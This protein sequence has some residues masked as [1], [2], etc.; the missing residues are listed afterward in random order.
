MVV[1]NLRFGLLGST[2]KSEF[3]I[4]I[5][6]IL[7]NQAGFFHAIGCKNNSRNIYN[8]LNGNHIVSSRS[9]QRY[10]K[11]QTKA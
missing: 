4:K 9:I 7:R 8:T 10:F 1:W 5:R 6:T 3:D 11:F 2:E